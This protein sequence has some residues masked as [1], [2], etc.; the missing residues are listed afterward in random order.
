M[1]PTQ[2]AEERPIDTTNSDNH[3]GIAKEHS[4][5]NE[6]IPENID[7]LVD[8]P[9]DGNETVE[10]TAKQCT[11]TLSSSP[12]GCN[13]QRTAHK[14]VHDNAVTPPG[15]TKRKGNIN[16]K[17]DSKGRKP[18]VKFEEPIVLRSDRIKT[19]RHVEKLRGMEYS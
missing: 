13:I 7:T 5:T 12:V 2:D 8:T 1:M 6:E 15:R 16:I 3:D 11:S 9:E 19:A 4:R 17:I 18:I 10:T 14:P